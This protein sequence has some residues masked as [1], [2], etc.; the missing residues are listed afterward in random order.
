MLADLLKRRVDSCYACADNCFASLEMVL[1]DSLG[2]QIR[3][4]IP[5]LGASSSVLGLE[6]QAVFP[7][8][9]S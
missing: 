4:I 6:A 2:C 9:C 7:F 5:S 1:S 3:M 8:L